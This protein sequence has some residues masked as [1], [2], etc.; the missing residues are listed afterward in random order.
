M[1][2]D[3]LT[4]ISIQIV[5]LLVFAMIGFYATINYIFVEKPLQD[6]AHKN[7]LGETFCKE[8]GLE[9]YNRGHSYNPNELQKLSDPIYCVENDRWY[10]LRCTEEFCFNTKL[11]QN[12]G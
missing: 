4:V 2:E 5:I 1:T 11:L 8:L 12:K 6:I 10:K 3:K 9:F 7:S